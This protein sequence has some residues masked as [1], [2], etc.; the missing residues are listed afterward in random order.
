MTDINKKRDVSKQ[1]SIRFQAV[2]DLFYIGTE[3]TM[4]LGKS[5]VIDLFE[6][7]KMSL[8]ASVIREVLRTVLA[9]RIIRVS[10]LVGL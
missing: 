1:K 5:V 3:E 8:H 2:N 9:E 10:P 4:L 6:S 7:L